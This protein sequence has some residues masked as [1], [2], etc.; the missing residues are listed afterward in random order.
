MKEIKLNQPASI[1]GG[2]YVFKKGDV[3]R[4]GDVPA[5]VFDL[6]LAGY[7]D[8]VKRAKAKKQEA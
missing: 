2:D 6:L 8:E 5:W 3:V 7:A 4:E 1:N